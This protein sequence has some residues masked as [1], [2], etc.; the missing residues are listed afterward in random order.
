MLMCVFDT[1]SRT[2]LIEQMQESIP[3]IED[4]EMIVLTQSVILRLERMS[5]AEFAAV[6]LF[7]DYGD[8][9]ETEV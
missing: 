8:N 4:D 3:D 9:E 2:G 1:S 6:A 7:P 5:D